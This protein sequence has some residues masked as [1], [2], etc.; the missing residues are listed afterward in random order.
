[1]AATQ[2]VV[3][4]V[5]AANGIAVDPCGTIDGRAYA[6]GVVEVPVLSA[7][8]VAAVE[9]AAAPF[10]YRAAA[11]FWAA[12]FGAVLLFFCL[13]LAAGSVLKVLRG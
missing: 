3:A 2:Y 6:P 4:C 8:T 10:D 12:S 1:M 9:A 13:G 5:P 7:A 11:E